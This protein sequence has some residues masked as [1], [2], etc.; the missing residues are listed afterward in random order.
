MDRAALP[1]PLRGPAWSRG[2]LRWLLACAL[3][4]W[5]LL[6]PLAMATAHASPPKAHPSSGHCAS[7]SPETDQHAPTKPSRCLSAC[8]AVEAA[9]PR[10]VERI[11]SALPRPPR[12][13]M[14]SLPEVLLERDPPPPRLS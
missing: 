4:C 12:P 2:G 3:V 6:A 7:S 14:K 8:A 13:A 9:A 1:A 5:G 11:G 10:I